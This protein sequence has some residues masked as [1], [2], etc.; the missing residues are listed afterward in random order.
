[1]VN[2]KMVTGFMEKK[3]YIV[4]FAEITILSTKELMGFTE[5]ISGGGTAANPAPARRTK[6]F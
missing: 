3:K 6:V 1:M 2:D 4:P 5:E